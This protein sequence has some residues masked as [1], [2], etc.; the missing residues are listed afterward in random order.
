VIGAHGDSPVTHATFRISPGYF[1]EFF[2]GFFVPE[3][4]QKCDRAIELLLRRSIARDRKVDAAE[5][6]A[7]LV[8]MLIGLLRFRRKRAKEHG[9]R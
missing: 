3:G 2:F 1:D 7:H 4:M 6:F 8:F 5:F 9:K